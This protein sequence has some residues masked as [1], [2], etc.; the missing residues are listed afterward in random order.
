[1]NTTSMD[2]TTQGSLLLVGID[3]AK[4]NLR[5]HCGNVEHRWAAGHVI[6]PSR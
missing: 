6:M 2:S 5:I 1:M 4:D 3:V